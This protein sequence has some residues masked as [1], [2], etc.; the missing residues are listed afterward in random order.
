MK[1][2]NEE[3]I[4][5]KAGDIWQNGDEYGMPNFQFVI[6]TTDTKARAGDK[7]HPHH[8]VYRPRRPNHET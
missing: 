4:D 1:P 3:W 6:G 2:N 5:L 8:M 7:V